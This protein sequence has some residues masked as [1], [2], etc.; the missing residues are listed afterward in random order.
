MCI[1][2]I[3]YKNLTLLSNKKRVLFVLYVTYLCDTVH[4]NNILHKNKFL[5]SEN[6]KTNKYIS[7]NKELHFVS[8]DDD[9]G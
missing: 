2:A 4:S 7:G 8:L 3:L 1:Y 9:I 6:Q 5:N